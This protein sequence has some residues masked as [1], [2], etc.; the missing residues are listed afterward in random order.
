MEADRASFLTADG[1]GDRELS[2]GELGVLT[3]SF[4]TAEPA[5]PGT[6]PEVSCRLEMARLESTNEEMVL[7]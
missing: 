5:L 1:D 6:P 4:T 2:K 7:R 3:S